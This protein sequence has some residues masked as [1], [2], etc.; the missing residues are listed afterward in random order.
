MKE[1]KK[2]QINGS[3]NDTST[4]VENKKNPTSGLA[5]TGL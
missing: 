4:D 3:S 5:V 2:T 1:L